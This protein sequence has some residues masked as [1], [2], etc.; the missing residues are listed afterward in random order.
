[1]GNYGYQDHNVELSGDLDTIKMKI[2]AFQGKNNLE[3]YLEW[4]KRVEWIF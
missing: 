4:E 2:L 1:M 3:V